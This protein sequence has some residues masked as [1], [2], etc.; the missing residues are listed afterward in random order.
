MSEVVFKTLSF[1]NFLS[2][3]N[4][5]TTINLD[6]KGSTLIIG[7]N[8]DE[9]GSSGSGKSSIVNALSY[10]LYDKIPTGV[11][12]DKLINNTNGSKKVLMEV[13]LTLSIGTD[14]YKIHR[15]R[16]ASNEVHLYQNDK[17]ITP[18][19]ITNVNL[20]IEDLIGFSYELFSQVIV[21][22][23]N[24]TPFLDLRLSDQRNLIEELMKIIM[25]SRNAEVLK[26]EIGE[27]DS[28]IK[29]SEA[30][31][32]QQK[33]Q[34]DKAKKQII[35]AE[36]RIVNW[37]TT[38]DTEIEKLS[39]DLQTIQE[40]ESSFKEQE[41]LKGVIDELT[42]SLNS[43][44]ADLKP[45]QLS[46]SQ[47]DSEYKKQSIQLVHL[48]DSKCPYCLQQFPDA[49]AKILEIETGVSELLNE[50]SELES[51]IQELIQSQRL[52][53][54][55]LQTAKT[56]FNVNAYNS[57]RQLINNKNVLEDRLS[58]RSIEV[59]PYIELLDS[60]LSEGETKLD[61]S[62][63]DSLVRLKEHQQLLLKM[64][65]DKNSFIRKAIIGKA[66]PFL[67]KRI[68]EYTDQLG[69]PHTVAFQPDMSCNISQYGRELDH[70]NLSNGEKKRLNIALCMAFRD[71]LTYIHSKVN[72]LF[73]DEIDGGSLCEN[74]IDKLAEM[75][76]HK[77]A[78]DDISMYY[79]SHNPFFQ[80][81]FSERLIV[82]KE[83]GFSSII[84][85]G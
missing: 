78:T 63:L 49:Q 74:T 11:S 12:K 8:L 9:G 19:S 1:R 6:R 55:E 58:K 18:D 71:S 72:V 15:C 61:T 17:D 7:E 68:A 22:N 67:N 29:I 25:L 14:Q 79:I 62:E 44:N 50:R 84:E 53:N 65:T 37:E 23:N 36:Q 34:Q 33:I 64:L 43:V 40:S 81:K 59:N 77:A 70:G 27:T 76:K 21:F 42:S 39:K 85:E 38:R 73:A 80:D 83:K 46:L 13:I 35:D 20:A 54:D 52:L 4:V 5:L 10:V 47:V 82:R 3:S 75:V 30:L 60:L 41:T 28:K 45:L 57:L 2:F 69:L 32:N 56:G 16:G 66:L 48:R 26:K 31:L 24:S 51:V